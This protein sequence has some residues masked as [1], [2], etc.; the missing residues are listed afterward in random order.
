M[1]TSTQRLRTVVD[2]LLDVSSLDSGRMH[3]YERD[4][5]FEACVDQAIADARTIIDEHQITIRRDPPTGGLEA[6]GDPDKLKR[7]FV[8]LIDNAVKFGAPGSEVGIGVTDHGRHLE[9][10]V[11]DEGPG[12]ARDQLEKVLEPFYQVRWTD[13]SPAAMAAWAW[14]WRTPVTSRRP[15][16]VA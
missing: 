16:A 6:R 15:S 7:A 1:Q 4:Y 10:L 8:H 9:L 3:F 14:G 11:A 12:L 2:T 5:D 13:R